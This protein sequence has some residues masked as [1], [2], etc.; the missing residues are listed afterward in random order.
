MEIKLIFIII[1]YPEI[2]LN[3]FN[4][5]SKLFVN[6]KQ[7]TTTYQSEWLK[8]TRLTVTSVGMWRKQNFHTLLVGM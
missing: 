4:S 6:S 2:L 8:I 5:S 3:S 7:G 1:L